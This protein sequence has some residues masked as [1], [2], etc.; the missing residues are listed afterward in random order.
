M[1]N[2]RVEAQKDHIAAATEAEA[3][4]KDRQLQQKLDKYAAVREKSGHKDQLKLQAAQ[5]KVQ[6]LS[7]VSQSETDCFYVVIA[8]SST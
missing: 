1:D 4:A 3:A 6:E 8:A 7:K 5:V 2:L